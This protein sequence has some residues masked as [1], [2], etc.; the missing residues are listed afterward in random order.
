MAKQIPQGERD[1]GR[2]VATVRQLVNEMAALSAEV[3]EQDN[4]YRFIDEA[5]TLS[6]DYKII[7]LSV[8]RSLDYG[9]LN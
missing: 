1:L 2:I 5:V 4:D 3:V 9:D 7:T 8:S 6:D